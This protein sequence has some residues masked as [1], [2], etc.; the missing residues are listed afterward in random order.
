MAADWQ[1]T[2]ATMI[3]RTVAGIAIAAMAMHRQL[4]KERLVAR[5]I[6]QIARQPAPQG[7][8]PFGQGKR[9][10][11]DRDGDGIGCE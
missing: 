2:A 9:R 5:S 1:L 11:L 4:R 8:L 7:L 10:H 6:F 3:R